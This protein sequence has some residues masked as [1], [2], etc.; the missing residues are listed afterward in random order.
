MILGNIYSSNGQNGN[1]HTTNDIS[2]AILSGQG[3][4]GNGIGSNN[5]PKIVEI[6]EDGRNDVSE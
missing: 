5:A 4:V 1:I 2:P 3:K 6:Y